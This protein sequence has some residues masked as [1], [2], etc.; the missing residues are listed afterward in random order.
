M[1]EYNTYR[2]KAYRF[3]SFEGLNNTIEN[4]TLRFSRSDALNDILDMH[5][6]L[7]I[8]EWDSIN[9]KDAKFL[10]FISSKTFELILSNL[11]ICCFCKEFDSDDAYLMWSH[12]AKNHTQVCFEI[13][14]SENSY[15]GGPSE[16][17]YSNNII[18]KRSDIQNKSTSDKG[19]FIATTKI[20][21]WSYEKEVRLIVD[22]SLSK[23]KAIIKNKTVNNRHIFVNFE[24]K[25]ISKVIFGAQA[26][27]D[28]ICYTMSLFLKKNLK[29]SFCKMWLDPVTLK[30]VPITIDFDT[31]SKRK[32]FSML[33]SL[34]N[35]KK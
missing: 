3:I 6:F 5:P 1:D 10:S 20:K 24:L 9:T 18:A 16:V 15:L 17:M 33:S 11:Y 14:F 12:Y 27:P 8:Y 26:N 35:S 32:E 25:L 19:M 22:T 13:D 2:D 7:A 30:L 31:L 4:E 23:T 21:Q 34:Y 28:D 29:P